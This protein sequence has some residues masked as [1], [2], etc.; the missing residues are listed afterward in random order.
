MSRM[1][2]KILCLI[3][4]IQTIT[5]INF[6]ANQATITKATT[7]PLSYVTPKT[8]SFVIY[9]GWVS[10]ISLVSDCILMICVV[11]AFQITQIKHWSAIVPIPPQAMSKR[12]S[13]NCWLVPITEIWCWRNT[14]SKSAVVD[15]CIRNSNMQFSAHIGRLVNRTTWSGDVVVRI[16]SVDVIEYGIL[17]CQLSGSKELWNKQKL[18]RKLSRLSCGKQARISVR[19]RRCPYTGDSIYFN[20]V[21]RSKWL[22]YA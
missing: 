22:A 2:G 17:M 6:L 13:S 9:N 8:S 18:A 1:Y 5:A 21:A 7:A 4:Y 3:I 16:G 14:V 10:K 19:L 11:A 15:L 12:K 20:L